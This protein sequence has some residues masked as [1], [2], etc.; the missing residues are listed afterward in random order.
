MDLIFIERLPYI[1]TQKAKAKRP[2]CHVL[3]HYFNKHVY[4]GTDFLHTSIWLG[5]LFGYFGRMRP[6][7]YTKTQ[8]STPLTSKQIT[9]NPSADSPREVIITFKRSKTNRHGARHEL[10]TMGCNCGH[11]RFGHPSPCP[12][13]LLLK[14][15]KMRK[16]R[17]GSM[18]ISEPIL[19]DHKNRMLKYDLLR[20]FIKRGILLVS[21]K[22]RIK[23]NPKYY[24]PH[25]LRVGGCTDL[26]RIGAALYKVSI[27]GRWTSDC[28]K[29]IYINIDFFDIARLRNTT[30]DELR[31]KL[32]KA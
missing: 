28:W 2:F 25:S 27:F 10:I 15:I 1:K 7:E 11:K 29:Q 14:F 32:W 5:M 8:Y 22:I 9:W 21:Q 26:S 17:F 30:V 24:T 4:I 16:Q 19:V 23:L 3:I 31:N 12:V 20:K 18:K 6:G 13:H